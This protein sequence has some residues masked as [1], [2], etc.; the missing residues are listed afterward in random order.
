MALGRPRRERELLTLGFVNGFQWAVC[1]PLK[2][3]GRYYVCKHFFFPQGSLFCPQSP[4]KGSV[5]WK[6]Q[7]LTLRCL[8]QRLPYIS[9]SFC[10]GPRYFLYF[11]TS[12]SCCLGV[13]GGDWC[14]HLVKIL[15]R[16]LTLPVPDVCPQSWK[17]GGPRSC[18]ELVL[19]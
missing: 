2:F 9:V 5:I 17:E 10:L 1:E 18:T 13:G 7:A 3:H 6:R 14:V 12:V 4:F 16:S 8:T 19:V 15:R 11:T